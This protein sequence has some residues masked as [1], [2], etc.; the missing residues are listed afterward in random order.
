MQCAGKLL[1]SAKSDDFGKKVGSGEEKVALL[2][3]LVSRVKVPSAGSEQKNVDMLKNTRL[4]PKQK[5]TTR[6]SPAIEWSVVS[7]S[8]VIAAVI[9]FVCFAC[10]C[11]CL[12]WLCCLSPFSVL[13]D[14]KQ[15]DFDETDFQRL[16]L[17]LAPTSALL[18]DDDN[19]ERSTKV[20]VIVRR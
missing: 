20:M 15:L 14:L 11:G 18:A 9:G 1:G 19:V 5:D 17:L 2:Q 16:L 6:S 3:K 13:Q 8:I 10:Q 4:P 12:A 7:I